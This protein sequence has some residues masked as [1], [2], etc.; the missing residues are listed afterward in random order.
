MISR[1]SRLKVFVVDSLSAQATQLI[2]RFS[3]QIDCEVIEAS[4]L[5]LH[6]PEA[7]ALIVRSTSP[8]TAKDFESAPLLKLVV[9]AGAGLDHID[10]KAATAR[11]IRVV[12]TPGAN[13]DAAADLSLALLLG[14]V[15]S[16]PQ[17]HRAV[18]DGRWLSAGSETLRKEFRGRNLSSLRIGIV[19]FGR[20][21]S[22]VADRLKGFGPQVWICDPYITPP[23][24]FAAR[25]VSFHRLLRE[26]DVV[27][28]H[29]PLTE[30]T[31]HFFNLK[32]LNDL[33]QP[34]FLVNTARGKIVEEKAVKEG[35]ERGLIAGYAT[36]VCE[37]EPPS[38][39]HWM[40]KDSRVIVTPHL[41]AQTLEAQEAVGL[42]AIQEIISFFQIS[43]DDTRG[44]DQ[45]D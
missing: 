23:T 31:E 18:Q 40:L 2:H 29:C 45:N 27:S 8:L 9:M 26:V 14:L 17:A 13:A 41:G 24:N 30:D 20:V 32:T 15:R 22:R 38:R 21:G 36:D 42:M 28:F 10:L 6:L 4:S 35:L 34:L 11:G 25:A 1:T 7:H 3:D 43:P 44:K 37:Q 19:G 33:K 16:L 12:G 5:G 39:D